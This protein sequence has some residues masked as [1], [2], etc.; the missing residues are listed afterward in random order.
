[1][2][3]NIRKVFF[4]TCISLVYIR[5][6]SYILRIKFALFVIIRFQHTFANVSQLLAKHL[7][8]LYDNRK[9]FA[10]VLRVLLR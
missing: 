4:I 3:V 10:I 1:M 9:L 2:L 6:Y 5:N 8:L 7:P